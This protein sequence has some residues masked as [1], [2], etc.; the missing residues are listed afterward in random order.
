VN[1]FEYHKPSSIKDAVALRKAKADG[2]F[3][4]G[5]Q[6]LIPVLKL[7][8]AEP[9]DLI[10]LAGLGELRG[11]RKDGNKLAIGALV[12]HDEVHRSP[13]VAGAIR[14]LAQLAGNIGDQQVRNRGTLG[15]SVAH[16]D[17]SADYPAASAVSKKPVK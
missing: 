11:I 13:E 5:G 7:E 12:T 2:K 10:A 15:G 9:S 8:L 4:A 3:L 6:S 1:K 14:A 16:A 17:P